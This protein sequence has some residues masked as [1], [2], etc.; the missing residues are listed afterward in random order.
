MDSD[1][2]RLILEL[3]QPAFFVGLMATLVVATLL[4]RW[5]HSQLSRRFK[6]AQL[7]STQEEYVVSA[8]VGLLALLLGFSF[9]MAVDHYDKRLQLVADEANAISSS[10]LMAQTFDAPDR[11]AIS[12]IL[13]DYV[14]IR[15][16]LSQIT[17]REE[18]EQLLEANLGAQR[19][20]WER[21]LE[22]V[23]GLRDDVASSYLQSVTDLIAVSQ[24]RLAARQAY[25]PSRVY[26]ILLIY[27]AISAVVLGYTCADSRQYFVNG[28]LFL[29]LTLSLVLIID[30]D[31]PT[32]GGIR[33]SQLAMENVR[34]RIHVE[35]TVE[36][37]AA[38][39][40]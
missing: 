37:P 4:G 34:M 16:K 14:D 12:V 28:I 19:R 32:S 30:L 36:T 2:E 40:Q 23:S 22:A 8:V 6:L 21:S 27:T 26:L 5:V 18:D 9:S 1:I 24:Q 38:P 33:E 11:D 7:G 31:R 20:L 3:P 39:H 29:L 13:S 17:S 10:Y 35:P 15:L 25:I